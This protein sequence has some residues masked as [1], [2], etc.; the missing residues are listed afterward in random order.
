MK[1]GMAEESEKHPRPVYVAW[2]PWII[3]FAGAYLM[4]S[5]FIYS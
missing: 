3:S 5:G 1:L 2:Q 4:E